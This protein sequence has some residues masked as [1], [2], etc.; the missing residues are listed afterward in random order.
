[1]SAGEGI[2]T[3]LV[4]VGAK[5]V[6]W[7]EYTG[8]LVAV[9]KNSDGMTITLQGTYVKGTHRVFVHAFKDSGD[10][11]ASFNLQNAGGV[12]YRCDGWVACECLIDNGYGL[13]GAAEQQQAA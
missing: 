3:A 10:V 13:L 9:G 8:K 12:Y 1:M 2:A 7:G 11:L 5:S 4:A 6:D